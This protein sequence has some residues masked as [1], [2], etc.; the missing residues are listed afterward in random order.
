[1]EVRRVGLS[2]AAAQTRA[3]LAEEPRP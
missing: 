3:F 1:V 2:E